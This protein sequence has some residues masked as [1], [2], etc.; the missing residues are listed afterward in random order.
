[1]GEPAVDAPAAGDAIRRRTRAP[2]SLAPTLALASEKPTVSDAAAAAAT[3]KVH[4]E[5]PQLAPA[6]PAAP[7]R[8]RKRRS[9]PRLGIACA[10]VGAAVTGLLVLTGEPGAA[11]PPAPNLVSLPENV[12]R[13]QIVRLVPGAAVSTTV[14]YS[15]RIAAGRVISQHPEAAARLRSDAHVQLVVSK[16]TPFAPVPGITVG[17][18]PAAATSTLAPSAFPSRNPL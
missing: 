15:T 4:P 3:F 11:G 6:A 17:E 8:A 12:A 18:T 16:G 9:Y 13:A 2:A 1:S 7:P 5:P 14:A 10:W